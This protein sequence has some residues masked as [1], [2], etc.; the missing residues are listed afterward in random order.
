M[1]INY[2]TRYNQ[3]QFFLKKIANTVINLNKNGFQ[4]HL[5]RTC[6]TV[7]VMQ[8]EQSNPKISYFL[9]VYASDSQVKCSHYYTMTNTTF[10]YV[11]RL[12][13]ALF[14]IFTTVHRYNSRWM[15]CVSSTRCAERR[16]Q[17]HRGGSYVMQ[18]WKL[19]PY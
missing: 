19:R 15:A 9:F 5:I 6:C 1:S 3:L 2:T 17:Q 18:D 11:H 16:H 10:T 8:L 4:Q 13:H 7:S 12:K 14:Y